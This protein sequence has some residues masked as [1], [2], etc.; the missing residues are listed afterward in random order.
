MENKKQY[1]LDI[2]ESCVKNTLISH[3]YTWA[4]GVNFR[5]KNQTKLPLSLMVFFRCV[6]EQVEF[7]LLEELDI[8]GLEDIT[9]IWEDNHD[10][11]SSFSQLKILLVHACNK[12]KNVIPPTMLRSSLTSEVDTLGSNTDSV[13]GRVSKRHV[14]AVSHNPNK[15]LQNVLTKTVHALRSV[16]RRTP[17]TREENLN[18]LSDILV[19]V[20][21]QNTRICPVVGIYLKG[22]PCLEKTGLN[23]GD[24]SGAVSLYPN[25]QTLEIEDCDRLENVF[26]PSLDTHLMNLEDMSVTKCIKM[27]EIIV[28]GKQQT[29]NGIVESPDR[30]ITFPQLSVINLKDLPSLQDFSPTTSYSF[31]MPQLNRFHLTRCPQVENKPFLQIMAEQVLVYSDEH[32]E[33]IQVRNLNEYTK[34]INKLESVGESSKSNQDVE[35]EEEE[36]RVVEQAEEGVVVQEENEIQ[37]DLKNLKKKN[38]NS[39][40]F[41]HLSFLSF[42]FSKC[43]GLVY[44][45]V[46]VC[47]GSGL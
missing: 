16:C 8:R 41:H 4:L 44:C 5:N 33:G 27:R 32:P 2:D 26:I 9:D 3:I 28:A 37:G 29:A 1:T 17:A 42:F 25:L 43:L 45:F 15:K 38:R 19:Q 24:Q 22:L 39:T 12:L 30:I 14:K 36:E 13:T 10:N 18:D 35:V 47:Q 23:C 46:F 31:K 21:S 40:V 20:P 34:R 7:P 6:F 11:V